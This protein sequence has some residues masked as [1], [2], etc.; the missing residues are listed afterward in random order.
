MN[1]SE[2]A[3]AAGLPV[4]TVRYYA[5]IGLVSPTSRSDAGY[6]TYDATA[7]R[8]LVFVRRARAFGFGIDACR[9]LLDLYQ[10]HGRSSAEVKQI[11]SR[12]LDEITLKQ[13]ELQ[14]L[15]DTL[16]HLVQSCRGDDRPDCP[17]IDYLG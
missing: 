6:R 12:R 15:H 17:I 3:K 9:E 7:L 16:S 1:I 11:A 5:D 14:A 8:K 13:R 2:A 4:K 10:D